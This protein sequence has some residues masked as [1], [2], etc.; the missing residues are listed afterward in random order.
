MNLSKLYSLP[1]ERMDGKRQGYVIAAIKEGEGI[2]ALLCADSNER[3]FL[4]EPG[5]I[6]RTGDSI[7]YRTESKRRIKG[8]VLRLNMPCYDER[9]RF[10]GH[11]EDYTLRQYTLKSCIV[12][13]KSYPA[14]RLCLGDIALIRGRDGAAAAIAAKDMFLE[15]VMG[16]DQ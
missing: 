14:A 2:A 4:I 12:G 10:L 13:G 8:T 9:G 5:E 6:V 11:I 3:E 7:V 15:A 16:E 1:A